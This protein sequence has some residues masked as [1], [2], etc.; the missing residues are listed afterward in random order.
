MRSIKYF[1][2]S[3]TKKK[4]NFLRTS[5]SGMTK[6]KKKKTLFYFFVS[7]GR[8]LPIFRFNEY[9]IY[10]VDKSFWRIIPRELM[11]KY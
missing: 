4:K 2:R 5:R 10:S 6:K 3:K 11:P 7:G 1:E 8:K 9:C